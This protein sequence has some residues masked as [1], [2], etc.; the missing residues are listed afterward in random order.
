MIFL[1]LGLIMGMEVFEQSRTLGL[2]VICLSGGFGAWLWRRPVLCSGVQ[3]ATVNTRAGN[4][5]SSVVNPH[6]QSLQCVPAL[7]GLHRTP[8]SG[9]R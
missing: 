8:L 7:M 1:T 2:A 4:W 3:S 9:R 6:N 5:L